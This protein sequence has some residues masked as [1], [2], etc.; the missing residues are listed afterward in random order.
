MASELI[1]VFYQTVVKNLNQLISN[2]HFA[3]SFDEIGG[4][5]FAL[6]S[7]LEDLSKANIMIPLHLF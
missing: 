7:T 4:N 1:N 5:S 3:K 2:V 6:L